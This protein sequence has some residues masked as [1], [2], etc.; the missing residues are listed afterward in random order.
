MTKT[1]AI[2]SRSLI[3]LAIAAVCI[4]ASACYSVEFI[5][6]ADY[7]GLRYLEAPPEIEVVYERPAGAVRRLGVVSIRDVA[8]PRSADFRDYVIEEA[9]RRGAPGAWI[10]ADQ[11]RRVP[12][13]TFGS[14][15]NP[16]DGIG[17]V[18]VVLFLR[19]EE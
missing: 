18:P 14:W 3:P 7:A 15:L 13:N 4:F 11:M 5:P 1:S 17:I 16:G 6:S 10:R 8:D 9:R 12:H 19:T 2:K